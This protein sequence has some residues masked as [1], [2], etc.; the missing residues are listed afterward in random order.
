MT[1]EA[2]RVDAENPWPGLDA[3]REKDQEFFHGRNPETEE[4]FRSVIRSPLTVLFGQSGLGKT[5]LLQAGLF[6]LLRNENILP[7]YIRLDFTSE[8]QKLSLQVR[9]TVINSALENV[10]EA[11]QLNEPE[12][13]WEFF[14]QCN[15]DFWNEKNQLIMPLLVFD[16]FEEIFTLGKSTHNQVIN[17]GLFIQEL[18]DLAEGRP[19]RRLKEFL[20]ANPKEAKNYNFSRHHYKILLSLREDYIP[21]LEEFR[22]QIPSISQNRIRLNRMNGKTALEVTTLAGNLINQ[23]VGEKIVRFVSAK[24]ASE[25]PLEKLEIEPAL[26]S[27]VCTELNNK[28]KNNNEP[29]ISDKLLEGSQEEIISSFYKRSISG[30]S[31][32]VQ[33]FIE[34]KLI[35]GTGFRDSFALDNALSNRGITEDVI[36]TLIDRRLIRKEERGGMQ[37]LELTH[38]LL[39]KVISTSR[40]Q[41]HQLEEIRK[42]EEESVLIERQKRLEEK[43]RS[44]KRLRFALIF[45]TFL[46][47]VSVFAML[48]A[49][50]Q[51]NKAKNSEIIAKEA[52]KEVEQERENIKRLLFATSN[53]INLRLLVLT[54]YKDS[55]TQILTK[56]PKERSITFKVTR[57]IATRGTKFLLF[58]D[59][60]SIRSSFNEIALMTYIMDHPTFQSQLYATGPTSRFTAV[61]EGV[62]CLTRVLV[63]IEYKD[64]LRSPSLAIFNMCELLGW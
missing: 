59:E 63:L 2:I 21:D 28:R 64:P 50:Q 58:P 36:K 7:V 22:G 34:E 49:I 1:T 32:E 33:I 45:V 31:S 51:T 24:G 25:I 56:L 57:S 11:P 44:A 60:R 18:A 48:Y 29:V 17:S 39:T 55:L 41:R 35:T 23:E 53:N 54:S 6:P 12:T 27:V 26:L 3:Y 52:T 13:L 40:N 14:H 61:Y 38:D 43:A 62:G 8:L 9:Q 4:L 30:F 5:S 19:P 16:Q 10:I 20:E 15:S 47:F 42:R 46:F 37:R